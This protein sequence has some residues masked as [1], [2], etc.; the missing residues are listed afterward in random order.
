MKDRLPGTVKLI[1][2]PGEE[3]PPPGEEDGAKLGVRALANLTVDYLR[4]PS[5]K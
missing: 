1:F 4:H 3:G 5:S 2:Q